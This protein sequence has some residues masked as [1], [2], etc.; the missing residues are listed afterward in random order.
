MSR[1][2]TDF[3]SPLPNA[4][5]TQIRKMRPK[6]GDSWTPRDRDIAGMRTQARA[7]W[8][9]PPHPVRGM[10]PGGLALRCLLLCSTQGYHSSESRRALPN[11]LSREEGGTRGHL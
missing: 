6:E 1:D 7:P 5:T 11:K 4:L 2:H 10:V 3:E 8:V 9:L